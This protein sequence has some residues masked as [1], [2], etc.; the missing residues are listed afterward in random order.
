MGRIRGERYHR[1]QQFRIFGKAQQLERVEAAKSRHVEIHQDDVEEVASVDRERLVSRR[2]D[3]DFVAGM[4]EDAREYLLVGDIVLNEQDRCR[5]PCFE[6]GWCRFIRRFLDRAGREGIAHRAFQQVERTV[7]REVGKSEIDP[8]R[9]V[10][11]QA[12]DI[13]RFRQLEVLDFGHQTFESRK[14]V[15]SQRDDG[16]GEG[17]GLEF[18]AEAGD[19]AVVGDRTHMAGK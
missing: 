9:A 2:H 11:G 8:A 3:G 6:K 18:P 17:A 14:R 10:R 19:G 16:A 4:F 12:D 5:M 15:R 13:D 1:R 7:A